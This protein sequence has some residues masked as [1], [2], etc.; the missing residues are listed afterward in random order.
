MTNIV[1]QPEVIEALVDC[2]V[3]VIQNKIDWNS[4][5]WQAV[6]EKA[7]KRP[8]GEWLPLKPLLVDSYHSRITFRCDQCRYIEA[9]RAKYCAGCG[10]YMRGENNEESN[11]NQN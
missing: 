5:D 9:Y 4:I 6:A 10:A 8:Q 2:V 7:V 1:V 11:S 3:D